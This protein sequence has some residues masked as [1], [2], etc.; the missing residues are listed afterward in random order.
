M[1]GRVAHAAVVFA[2]LLGALPAAA[3]A[4]VSFEAGTGY[5]TGGNPLEVAAGDLNGDGSPDLVSADNTGGTVTSLLNDGHGAFTKK[6][7]YPT[8]TPLF[9]GPG[10]L[11]LG[12]FLGSGH[13]DAAVLNITTPYE[14]ELVPGAGDGGFGAIAAAKPQP[15]GYSEAIAG[16]PLTA[17]GRSDLV[18]ADSAGNRLDVFLANGNGSFTTKPTLSSSGFNSPADVKI[19]DVN[20][21]G[22]PDVVAAGPGGVD[23]F[24]GKGDGTFQTGVRSDTS[25]ALRQIALADFNGDGHL[26]VGYIDGASPS[27]AG[28][29]LGAGNGSFAAPVSPQLT[30]TDTESVAAADLDG[31]GRADLV[32]TSYTPNT[33]SIFMSNGDGT[34]SSRKDTTLNTP[35]GLALA[36]FNG[37]GNTDLAIAAGQQNKAFVYLSKPPTASLSASSVAFPR[38]AV[39]ATATQALTLT[40]TSAA[41]LPDV[42]ARLSLSGTNAGDFSASGCA[43]PLAPGASCTI[44]VGFKPGAPGARSAALRI[45][46]NAAGG[47][48]SVALTGSGTLIPVLSAARQSHA[49]W[50]VGKS[51]KKHAAPTGTTFSFRLNEAATVTLSFSK[52]SHKLGVRTVKGRAGANKVSFSGRL[53]HHLLRP[54][55]YQV[56]IVATNAEGNSSVAARFSFKIVA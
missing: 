1:P 42:D 27:H 43:A 37:D 39:G 29:L 11:A 6:N 52:R 44:T 26:D 5:A 4:G 48:Q 21:D 56:T 51:H 8:S 35:R 3:Q 18:L 9:G 16:G 22:V 24:L 12:S 2:L 46:D 23:A 53:G 20:G 47:G 30:P 13:L 34:L 7:S 41:S 33:F 38:T 28:V 36:D 54:G 40:N 17:D 45:A 50:R 32:S 31:D 19:G 55:K 25:I 49:K 14:V 10:H 15:S